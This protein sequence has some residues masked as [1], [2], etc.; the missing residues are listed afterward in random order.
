MGGNEPSPGAHE[1]G[2]SLGSDG[3]SGQAW[4]GSQLGVL[5]FP[6]CWEGDAVAEASL[7]LATELVFHH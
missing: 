2:P 5:L 4:P 6:K 3:A 1:R 7:Y